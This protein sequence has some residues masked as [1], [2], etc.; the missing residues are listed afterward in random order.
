MA[1]SPVCSNFDSSIVLL[2]VTEASV[3]TTMDSLPASEHRNILAFLGRDPKDSAS[4]SAVSIALKDSA[5]N[6][7]YINLAQL[8]T[9]WLEPEWHRRAESW[10]HIDNT[11]VLTNLMCAFRHDP[12]GWQALRRIWLRQFAML[13]IEEV[14]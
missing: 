4:L 11:M 12:E 7:R 8:V 5:Q 3:D 1:L 10:F 13:G 14:D 6:G 9:K 2:L